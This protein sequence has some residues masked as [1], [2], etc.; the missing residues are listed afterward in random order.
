VISDIPPLYLEENILI[1]AFTQEEVFEGL[2]IRNKHNKAP[3]PDGFPTE[4]Y[5]TFWE[6]IKHNFMA[7]FSKLQQKELPLHEPNFGIQFL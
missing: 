7:L 6:L 3:R 2:Y 4:F 1:A 5:Q